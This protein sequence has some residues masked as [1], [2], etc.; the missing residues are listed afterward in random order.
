MAASRAACEV[1]LVQ[2]APVSHL[3]PYTAHPETTG[4]TRTRTMITM[5]IL[6]LFF[7]VVVTL[8]IFGF[9]SFFFTPFVFF[10]LLALFVSFVNVLVL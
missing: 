9:S 3:S 2:D 7:H 8:S 10:A 6:D 4:N 1:L 5:T